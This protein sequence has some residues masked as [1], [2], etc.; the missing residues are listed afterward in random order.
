MDA[1]KTSGVNSFKSEHGTAF[2]QEVTTV[3][4]KDWD[5]VLSHVKGTDSYELLTKGVNKS[6]VTE[7]VETN[8]EP[9]PGVGFGKRVSVKFR[10]ASS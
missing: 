6:V 2:L 7:F 9:P 10:K 1:A 4:V 8:R 5:A 3:S